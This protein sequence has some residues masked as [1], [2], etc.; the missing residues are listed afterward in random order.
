MNDGVW[1]LNFDFEGRNKVVELS[2]IL[3]S[4]SCALKLHNVKLID[5]DFSEIGVF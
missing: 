3:S 5:F 4:K 1:V 2:L